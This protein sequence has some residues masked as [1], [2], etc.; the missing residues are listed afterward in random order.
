MNKETEEMGKCRLIY[1]YIY[2]YIYILH[3]VW[4]REGERQRLLWIALLVWCCWLM[5]HDPLLCTDTSI[6]AGD[7]TLVPCDLILSVLINSNLEISKWGAGI[8]RTLACLNLDIDM[9]FKS[10]K[11]WGAGH[12]FPDS[13]WGKL[14]AEFRIF[15]ICCLPCFPEP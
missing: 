11:T 1:I 13:T 15:H 2:I 5:L 8:P 9:P 12:L 6:V 7:P 3:R 4:E 10:S 14:A